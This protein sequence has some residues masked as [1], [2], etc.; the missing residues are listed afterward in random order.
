MQ[1][2]YPAVTTIAIILTPLKSKLETFWY[3]L[4]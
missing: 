3:R 1:V 2:I 4:T